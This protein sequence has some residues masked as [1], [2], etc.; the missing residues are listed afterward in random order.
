[1]NVQRPRGG[2]REK[3]YDRS[4]VE[5]LMRKRD[6]RDYDQMIAWLRQ[7]GDAD[8]RLTPGEVHHLVDDLSRVKQRGA[9]FITD[10]AQLYRELKRR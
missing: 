1:M 8:N 3:D 2:L 7:Q 10:P 9:G 4:D 6:W 5:H